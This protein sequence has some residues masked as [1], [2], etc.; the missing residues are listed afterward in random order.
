MEKFP[1]FQKKV[2][3]KN[4]EDVKKKRKLCWE[5]RNDIPCEN[6]FLHL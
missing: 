3:Y 1:R 5:A 6:I 2:E 4:F